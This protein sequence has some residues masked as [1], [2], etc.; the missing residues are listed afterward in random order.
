MSEILKYPAEIAG[1]I[2]AI[3]AKVD[4]VQKKGTNT[5]HGYKFAAV[6]DLLAKLQP[7]MAE[8]GLIVVQ[9]EVKHQISPNGTVMEVEYEFTLIH[10]SGAV[11]PDKPKH[12]GM[13][14]AV[15]SKGGF[16]DKCVN[17][18]MT[19]ARKYF[20][21]ALFQIPTGEDADPDADQDQP[22]T[23][24]KPHR[25][26]L[27]PPVDGPPQENEPPVIASPGAGAQPAAW[28][29]YAKQLVEIA[30]E[31]PDADWFNRFEAVNRP[32]LTAM[33]KVSEATYAWTQQ[34][35]AEI[36]DQM[37]VAA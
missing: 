3:M 23:Q 37:R 24:A 18:C 27:P 29:T 16:D 13:A 28:K 10:K 17:K 15:N 19:A 7:A 36:L 6:G 4:Y 25:Q 14:T 32:G 5:F 21:L 2:N 12:T 8:A 22:K 30:R 9:N 33:Q 31:A 1:A 20:L 34:R 11:W 26:A 35:L